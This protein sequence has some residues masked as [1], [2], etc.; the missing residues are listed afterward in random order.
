MVLDYI[1]TCVWTGR[2]SKR[3]LINHGFELTKNVNLSMDEI[4]KLSKEKPENKL[5]SDVK[6]EREFECRYMSLNSCLNR[7]FETALEYASEGLE[8]NPKSAYLHYMRGQVYSNLC[9]W[10]EGITDLEKAVDL[11]P[12]YFRAQ[13]ELA[14][15]YFNK[16]LYSQL[17]EEKDLSKE[18]KLDSDFKKA[19]DNLDEAIKSDERRSEPYELKGR[20]Y[21]M[22]GK[23]FLAKENLEKALKL[24]PENIDSEKL[25]QEIKAVGE[26]YF[27]EG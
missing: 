11:E 27:L 10:E 25:L 23:H 14:I 17:G 1:K 15:L 5:Y 8:M 20:I 24:C 22:C 6:S 21:F 9:R 19:I 16:G 4:R 18:F 3:E 2:K 26:K 12:N 7:D 13:L